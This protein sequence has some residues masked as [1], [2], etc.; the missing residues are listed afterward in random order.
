[1]C[2]KGFIICTGGA[3][4]PLVTGPRIVDIEFNPKS[5]KNISETVDPMTLIFIIA[6]IVLAVT[7]WFL[8]LYY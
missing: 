7:I 5:K 6:N 8:T 1:M 4:F 2:V 3:L